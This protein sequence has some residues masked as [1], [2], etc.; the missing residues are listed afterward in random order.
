LTCSNL[1]F[2]W[3]ILSSETIN[4]T[5]GKVIGSVS[6]AKSEDVDVAVKVAS[7]AFEKAWGLKTPGASRGKMLM[8]LADK[9]EANLDTFAVQ[10]FLAPR[11]R[12]FMLSLSI[13]SAGDSTC[14]NF[15]FFQS[16]QN[17]ITIIRQITT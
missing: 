15:C 12:T 16:T 4:P 5:N 3:V 13:K 9:I 17:I 2:A 14:N 7:E 10:L 6:E 8:H 11:P 1:I